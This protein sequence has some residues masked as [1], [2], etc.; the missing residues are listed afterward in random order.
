MKKYFVS[1]DIHGFYSEWMFAL[2]NKGFDINNPDHIIII[3]GDLLDRGSEAKSLVNFVYDMLKK[4]RAILIKGNHEDLFQ[5][6][7]N[8]KQPFYNDIT[9]GTYDTLFQLTYPGFS[10]YDFNY[11]VRWDEIIKSMVNYYE[12]GD[13]IFVHGW[14]PT[15][16]LYDPEWRNASEEQWKKARWLNGIERWF[17]GCKEPGKTIVCGHWHCSYG[18]S[19]IRKEREEFPDKRVEGWEKSFEPFIDDGII[20]IDACTAYSHIVNVLVLEVDNEEKINNS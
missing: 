10:P 13:Y 7:V 9:N 6:M 16:D 11:D 8:R 14:I 19:K 15:K 17:S 2:K 20:A 12:L 5:D 3:C 4:G 1:A 18:W